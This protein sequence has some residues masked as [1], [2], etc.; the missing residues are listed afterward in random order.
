MTSEENAKLQKA[1]AN[2]EKGI[3]WINTIDN[4]IRWNNTL[5]NT[6]EIINVCDY[7]P[8]KWAGRIAMQQSINDLAEILHQ[9]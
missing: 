9:E 6:E 4:K 3:E 5:G 1:I 2:L 7:M 8:N